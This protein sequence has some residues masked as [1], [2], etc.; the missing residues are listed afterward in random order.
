MSGQSG[1]FIEDLT[2]GMADEIS[3]VVT[4]AM[5]EQFAAVSGDDNPLHLDDDYAA[6]TVFKGRI[7]HGMLGASFISAIVGTRLPGPGTIYMNQSL[8]FSAPVR[9]NDVIV[10]RVE[11]ADINTE[12]KRV[13]LRTTCRV[14]NTVVIDGEAL[15]M[16][17]SR[18]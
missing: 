7:A 8:K 11:V 2:V 18:G 16:V 10:T 1:Y 15:V 3:N 12:K 4:D 17:P 13:T 9:I 14:A 6:T 5:V